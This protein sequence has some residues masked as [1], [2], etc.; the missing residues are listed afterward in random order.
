VPR[1]TAEDRV[2]Y[3]GRAYEIADG[4]EIGEAQVITAATGAV[5]TA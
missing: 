4:K 5:A 1:G 3:E 2:I